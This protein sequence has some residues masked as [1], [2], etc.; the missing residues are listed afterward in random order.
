MAESRSNGAA[1]ILAGIATLLVV[2][3]VGTG[4][5]ALVGALLGNDEVAVHQTVAGDH[6]ERLP[7]SVLPPSSVDVT[8][9][10]RD[11]SREQRLLAAGRDAVVIVPL[12]TIMWLARGL[13]RSVPDGDP[14]TAVN[15]RRLRGI[16]FLCLL[17]LPAVSLLTTAFEDA[18]AATTS[19]GTILD[20]PFGISEAGP[21]VGLGVFALA[22]VFARGVRLRDDV[23][24]TI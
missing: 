8:I 13:F 7:A 9:R 20:T 15:V 21:L 10:I 18:L 3:G 23:E 17:G 14:F 19:T 12:V 24:G 11:A 1:T 5:Y 2:V 6:V 22:E 16:G 4:V